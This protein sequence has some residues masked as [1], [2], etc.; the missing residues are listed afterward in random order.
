M[1]L[2]AA[3]LMVIGGLL[4][5]S[6]SHAAPPITAIAF[7]PGGKEVVAASQAGVVVH[8]WPSLEK[9]REIAGDLSHVNDAAFSPDG[10]WLAICG[11]EPSV[12]G[13]FQLVSWPDGKPLAAREVLSDV[14]YQLAWRGSD[15]LALAGADGQLILTNLAGE[16]L[17]RFIGH[18]R[19][20]LCVAMTGDDK[21]LLSGSGD[22]SV[23]VWN[24]ASGELQR[25]L[26]NHTGDV[27]DLALRPQQQGVP[28]VA[29]A[30]GDKTVRFWQPTI[31]RMVR[32]ARLDSAP[33]ALS[34]SPDGRN[35]LAACEDGRL[36]VVAGD[37][38]RVVQ[39]ADALDGWAYAVA[40]APHGESVVVAGESG[41]MRAVSF[42]AASGE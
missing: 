25:T 21:V 8:A 9:Q 2:F 37:T 38:A 23:R 40:A 34:W 35:L 4:S 3:A 33:L 41:Q 5:G 17:R 12:S 6:A 27:R 13:G 7:A 42:S 18:S 19:D 36:R 15:E 11:G 39:T 31:G 1:R 28:L 26:S 24:A 30:G 14:A 16:V 22:Q 29:S 20:V 32:F 10:K